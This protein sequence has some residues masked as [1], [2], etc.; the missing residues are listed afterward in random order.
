VAE[1]TKAG[2]LGVLAVISYSPA[3]L[4]AILTWM[5]E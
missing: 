3:E 2:G 5:D 1:V 4:D